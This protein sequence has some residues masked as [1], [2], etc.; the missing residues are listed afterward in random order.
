MQQTLLE[1]VINTLIDDVSHMPIVFDEDMLPDVLKSLSDSVEV[2]PMYPLVIRL[3]SQQLDP[4]QMR[5]E[6][7][8]VESDPPI[9]VVYELSRSVVDHRPMYVMRH[10]EENTNEST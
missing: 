2:S 4:D 7:I 1:T 6:L 8:S 3:F 9:R 10:I 5:F